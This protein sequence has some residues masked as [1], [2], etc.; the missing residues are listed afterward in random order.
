M[1]DKNVQ[2]KD[3]EINL[4]PRTKAE[5]VEGLGSLLAAKANQADLETLETKVGNDSLNIKF[6][7]SVHTIIDAVNNLKDDLD[8]IA[9]ELITCQE[10]L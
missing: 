1:S 3:Q 7:S 5:I 6:D 2:L 4:Y 8:D 10:I 9:D